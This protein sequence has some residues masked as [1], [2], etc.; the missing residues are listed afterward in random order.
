M[1]EVKEIKEEVKEANKVNYSEVDTIMHY[2]LYDELYNKLNEDGY[3]VT[4]A[5]IWK[6]SEWLYSRIA[7]LLDEGKNVRIE[8]LCTF[9]HKNKAAREARNPQTGEKV[10]VPARDVVKIR[11]LRR[12]LDTTKIIEE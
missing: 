10:N 1:E 3:K 9:E 12:V 4:K 8:K 11:P 7:E 5:S 6:Y 2:M